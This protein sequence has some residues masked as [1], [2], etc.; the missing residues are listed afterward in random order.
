MKYRLYTTSQKA[1]DGMF[2]AMAAAQ[3]S[4]Y[5]EMYTFVG[6][7]Q[8][9][10]DF[11]KLLKDRAVAG[12]EVVVVADIYGSMSLRNEAVAELRA[13]GVEFLYFSRWFRRTH[14]KIIIIDSRVAFIGG[15][16]IEEETRH[17]IDL[18]IK[19][20]GRIVRPLLKSFAYSY[21]IS[22]GKRES[23]LQFYRQPLV[24]KLEAWITDNWPHTAKIY[25]LN[26]Y[27]KKKI[28]EAQTSIT[29]VTP[30]LLPP[31]WLIGLLGDAHRRGVK[32]EVIIPNNTDVGPVNK[33]N[34]L[35]ACRLTELGVKFYLLP[36]MNH[37]KIMLIDGREGVIGSQNM[38]VLSFNWNVE[39]GVFFRQKDLVADL[40]R[41]VEQWKKSAVEFSA[42]RRKITWLDKI[43]IAVLKLF[44][45]IL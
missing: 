2:K 38:D 35:N 10:H 12:I 7:T 44:Y 41:I 36:T 33:V 13:V 26:N 43:L 14:R 34:Y 31:S 27:Y 11:L 18:Q 9:T 5:I 24:Q 16:N 19:L 6:D 45:P 17:W 37:A 39:A 20:E 21:E 22:G 23:I 3:K 4:I 28:M 8:R 32:V 15:V 29:I 42:A 25:Y 40:G 1:W 30:Y